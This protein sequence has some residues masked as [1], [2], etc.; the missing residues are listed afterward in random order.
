MRGSGD[1]IAHKYQRV[2]V[3]ILYASSQARE[4]LRMRVVLLA[5]DAECVW[6]LA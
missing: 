2:R 6:G 1:Y 3:R 4:I 5:G